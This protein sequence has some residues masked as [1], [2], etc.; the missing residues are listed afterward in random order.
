MKIYVYI[1]Y[2]LIVKIALVYIILLYIWL[3]FSLPL[4][5]SPCKI[6]MFNTG[7][8]NQ[9]KILVTLKK[10]SILVGRKVSVIGKNVSVAVRGIKK[11]N[12]T[13]FS[14]SSDQLTQPTW[15]W[16]LYSLRLS[17][18]PTFAMQ[19]TCNQAKV[20]LSYIRTY[21]HTYI[22]IYLTFHPRT[23]TQ[24]HTDRCIW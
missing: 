22:Y 5:F 24:T 14:Q 2:I 21:I 1:E 16:G 4:V 15:G 17:V 10:K 12:D 23:H 19:G 11:K 7:R 18:W 6:K 8:N 9:I 20:P 13:N 3:S